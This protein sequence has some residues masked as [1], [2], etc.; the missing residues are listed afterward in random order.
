MPLATALVPHPCQSP[1]LWERKERKISVG[2]GAGGK[3][4][5]HH[6]HSW[7]GCGQADSSKTPQIGQ[8]L[9]PT[10]QSSHHHHLL[11]LPGSCVTP[12][13]PAGAGLG[14]PCS[15][16][17]ILLGLV[18]NPK[19]LARSTEGWG[20][21]WICL[22]NSYPHYHTSTQ[23]CISHTDT[24]SHT[25]RGSGAYQSALPSPMLHSGQCVNGEPGII[26]HF[27]WWVGTHIFAQI[28]RHNVHKKSAQSSFNYQA[29][30][31][32]ELYDLGQVT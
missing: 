15:F 18:D 28:H 21:L 29:L 4:S 13:L 32:D 17:S 24:L 22:G 30:N 14:H 25:H 8:G 27:P 19:A 12:D 2:G 23:T 10:K 31:I 7:G 1:S 11:L 20:M 16:P 9:N 6:H 5:F 3:P 26:S